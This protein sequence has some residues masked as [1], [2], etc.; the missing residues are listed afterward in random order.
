[1][2]LFFLIIAAM[3]SFLACLLTWSGAIPQHESGVTIF[4]F[5]S[6]CDAAPNTSLLRDTTFSALW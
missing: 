2:S 5:P 6:M 4:T 1:M 3:Y